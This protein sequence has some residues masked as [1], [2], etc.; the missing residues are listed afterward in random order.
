MTKHRASTDIAATFD[1]NT[2]LCPSCGSPNLHHNRVEIFERRHEDSPEGFH[3]A[4]DCDAASATIDSAIVGNPSERRGG[5]SVMLWCER[6]EG[7]SRIDLAQDK[8]RT[9]ISL[10]ADRS[11]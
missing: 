2:L 5:I 3:V 10:K 6:C 1:G 11:A 7:T 9:L 4:V 8:G